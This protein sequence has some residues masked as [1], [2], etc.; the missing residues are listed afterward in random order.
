MRI[1]IA[2]AAITLVTTPAMATGSAADGRR[3]F[4]RCAGCHSVE[5]AHN[6]IGPS[7][8]AIVGRKSATAPGYRYS[9]ALQSANI[10]WNDDTLDRFLSDPQ[11]LVHGTKMF[12][13]VPDARQRQNIIAFLD[14]LK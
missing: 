2:M 14:T 3:E 10:T 4:S 6:G 5:P 1:T 13:G 12:G 8:A 9:P 11:G 7:L